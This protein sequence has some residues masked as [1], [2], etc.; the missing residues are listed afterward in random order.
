[1]SLQRWTGRPRSTGFLGGVLFLVGAVALLVFLAVLAA[2]GLLV[3]ALVGVLMVA[4]RLLALLV[5][6]YR[7][8]RRERYLTMPAGLIRMVRFGSGPTQVVDARSYEVPDGVA[9][10]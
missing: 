9:R 5:P 4:E 7:R 6:A 2:L 8:R 10:R 3:M 1:M